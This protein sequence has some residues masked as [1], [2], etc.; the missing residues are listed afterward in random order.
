ME[1]CLARAAAQPPSSGALVRAQAAKALHA[2]CVDGRSLTDALSANAVA[3]DPRDDAL[4]HELSFGALRF[5]PRLQALSERLLQRPLKPNDR[6]LGSLLMIG[7][8][9]LLELRIPDH[10]SVSATVAATRLLQRP[11]AAGLIN[12]T[13]RRFQRER[14]QLLAQIEQD[15]AA[16]WLMPT[17]LLHRLRHAWPDE[18]EAI[19]AA[20]NGR[21]PMFLR[22]NSMR[23]SVAAY[24]E[25]LAAA[26]I[27]AQTQPEQPQALRLSSPTSASSLPGFEAGLVSVQDAGAQWAAAVLAPQRGDRVLDACAAPGGKSAHL[28]ESAAGAIHLTAIDVNA[29][30]LETLDAN[31]QRLGLRA[32]LMTGDATQPDSMWADAPYQ[33]ILLDAPCSATGVMR[34]HPDI[35]ALRREQDITALTRT[36]AAMLEALWPQLEPSGSLLYVTCSLLPEENEAQISAFLRRHNDAAEQPLS[37]R[38]GIERRHGRQLLPTDEGADGFY[39]ALLTKQGPATGLKRAGNTGHEAH[40]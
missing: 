1:P 4:L 28:L 16:H 17:W 36:Q 18:W 21:G 20:S 30:R 40:P 22:V 34:R 11:R 13:L 38:L 14:D 24:L 26:G 2:V 37:E 32:R 9:Q 27:A 29:E 35:K 25:R 7:L 8:Y 23:I 15:D 5:L 33:R 12:A 3:A 31:L 6:I 39:F 10:A 19:V